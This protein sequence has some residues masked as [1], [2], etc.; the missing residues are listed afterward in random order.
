MLD[1]FFN[2]TKK[3]KDLLS[4]VSALKIVFETL[5]PLPHIE[6]NIRRESLLKSSL[7]S[8]R[9]EG[10][11]L[12]LSNVKEIKEES[13]PEDLKKLEVANLLKAYR[14]V[15]LGKVPDSLSESLISNLHFMTL[16]GISENAGKYRGEPWAIFNQAGEVVHLAP[17]A[18]Q[19][20]QL[21][22]ELVENTT[23]SK[24]PPPIKA[25]IAQFILEKI[26]PFADGNGRVG[27]LLS[28]YL[29]KM[30]DFGFK[31]LVSFEE[32][33]DENRPLYYEALD[34][35]KEMTVFVEFFLESL[36]VQA[37]KILEKLKVKGEEFPEDSLLP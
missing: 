12:N 37:K 13:E 34:S 7:Y 6:E 18:A 16:K 3:I 20:S 19:V 36:V 27:R 5:T 10:N 35:E 32:F 8:A 24:A 15:Y 33:I 30:G 14:F 25:A 2:E 28:A 11:P 22:Q 1:Y 31:G 9:V 23:V 26:H 17:P 4:E 21:M 29:L